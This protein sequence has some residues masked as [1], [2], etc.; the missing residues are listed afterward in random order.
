MK[1]S[2]PLA[3]SRILLAVLLLQLTLGGYVSARAEVPAARLLSYA[4]LVA[5]YDQD[6][7]NG[8][9]RAKLDF[10]LTNAFISNQHPPA[11]AIKNEAPLGEYIRIAHWNIQRGIELD[12]IKA[13]FS[14]EVAFRAI[15]D[16][17]KFR[18]GA[19][20]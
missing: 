11:P 17:E 2:P 9:L 16:R 12:A 10:L 20:A 5:L 7:P 19:S 8:E 13:L 18:G 6:T 15:L 14:G 1:P 4:D 3:I